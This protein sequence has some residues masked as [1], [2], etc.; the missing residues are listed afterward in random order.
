[1]LNLV[2]NSITDVI[3]IFKGYPKQDVSACFEPKSRRWMW[4]LD[5][6][7]ICVEIN[8]FDIG[9]NPGTGAGLNALTK[10]LM[11]KAWPEEKKKSEVIGAMG[12]PLYPPGSTPSQI[13]GKD[14]PETTQSNKTQ[15]TQKAVPKEDSA[16]DEYEEDRFDII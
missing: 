16:E 7:Q 15:K 8:E 4:I 5:N 12:A 9:Y 2:A 6:D 1:M 10:G 3:T 14:P 11:N 13:V